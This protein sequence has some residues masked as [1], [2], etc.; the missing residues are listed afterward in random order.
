[1]EGEPTKESVYFTLISKA[2]NLIDSIDKKTKILQ[3]QQGENLK[4]E[5]LPL[6]S[7]LQS[8]LEGICH[9]LQGLLDSYK[10]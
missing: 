5:A 3:I 8:E 4:K 1:M 10:D 7:P 2:H 6:M 9:H